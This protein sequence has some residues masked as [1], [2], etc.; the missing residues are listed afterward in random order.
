MNVPGTAMVLRRDEKPTMRPVTTS[1][2][3]LPERRKVMGTRPMML[4]ESWGRPRVPAKPK[5]YS[6]RY[7]REVMMGTSS[8]G[9]HSHSSGLMSRKSSGMDS[10]NM[11]V[12]IL[13]SPRP[14]EAIT[15]KLALVKAPTLR[16]QGCFSSLLMSLAEKP[17]SAFLRPRVVNVDTGREIIM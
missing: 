5:L 16:I 14:I 4:S 11:Y 15:L 9:F 2:R 8:P 13:E 7:S 10:R 6:A 1:E 17:L 12:D 3:P